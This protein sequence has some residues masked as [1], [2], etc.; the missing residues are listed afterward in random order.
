MTTATATP[1]PQGER[2]MDRRYGL[3]LHW[4]PSSVVGQEIS[5]SREFDRPE[6]LN[7]PRAHEVS[8]RVCIPAALYDTLY[9]HFDGRD[10]DAPALVEKAKRWGHRYIYLTTKHH[11]G[12]CMFDTAATDYKSTAP[13]CPAG[14]DFVRELADACHAGGMGFGVYYSQPDW[15]HPDYRTENHD[16]YIDYL[17]AQVEELCTKYGPIDTWWFDGLAGDSQVTGRP[18]PKPFER[19]A[20][21]AR[22]RAEE[23][24]TKMR[25][26]QPDMAINERC[27]LPCD[28]DTPEQRVGEYR[29][30]R[31]WESTITLG[32]QWAYSFNERVKHTDDVIGFL[33]DAACGGGNYVVN[34]GPDRYGN[35]PPEQERVLDG[36]GRWLERYGHTIYGTR[37]GPW[38][39]WIWGGSTHREGKVWIHVRRWPERYATLE[40]HLGGGTLRGEPRLVTPGSLDHR[41]E[42]GT[43]YLILPVRD[44]DGIDAIVEV[45]F[46]TMPR[47]D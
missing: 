35:V 23:L 22:W 15:H 1:T 19:P 7:K 16:R 31:P 6:I 18:A 34:V 21:P 44:H 41:V 29:P 8:P 45:D 3:F 5:W 40:L 24:I 28:F 30:E 10:F 36:V 9:R 17:H 12:F 38:P 11:D 20:D 47:F 43:L 39:R 33:I 37:A 4:N 32:D 25:R 27:A 14:R 42:D 2:F 46:D 26:W 13:E